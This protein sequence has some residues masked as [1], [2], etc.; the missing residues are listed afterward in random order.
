MHGRRQLSGGLDEFMR[1]GYQDAVLKAF[2]PQV[3]Q[4]VHEFPGGARRARLAVGDGP[5]GG[6][7]IHGNHGTASSVETC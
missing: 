2:E 5:I 4:A 6:S 3:S 7:R 1:Q